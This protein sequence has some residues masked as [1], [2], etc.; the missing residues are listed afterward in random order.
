MKKQLLFLLVILVSFQINSQT[1]GVTK[2][3]ATTIYSQE[4]RKMVST[5]DGGYLAMSNSGLHGRICKMNSGYVPLWSF[6]IDS[7]PIFDAVETN[8]GN[9]VFTGI[10]YYSAYASGSVY[11]LKLNPTGTII[12]QKMYY[13]PSF[14][15]TLTTSGLG[16][17][18]G[19]D[20]G[21]V[22]FGGN[23]M[24]MHYMVKCDVNGV[25]QWENTYSGFGANGFF[26]SVITETNGY[27][28]D[29]STSINS[30]GAVYVLR[31]DANGVPS[32]AKVMQSANNLQFGFNSLAKLNNGDYFLWVQPGDINGA[33][34]Y[35]ISNSFSTITCNRISDNSGSTYF[36]GAIATGNANDDL[37]MTFVSYNTFYSGA[38]QVTPAGSI[39]WQ[40]YSSSSSNVFNAICA[41]PLHNG[42]NL[43]NGNIGNQKAAIAILDD[44]GNGF[45]STQNT[46]LTAT[47]NY[48]FTLTSPTI[49]PYPITIGVANVNFPVTNL[50]YTFQ[51]ICGNL[52]GVTENEI[53]IDAVNLF[54][55]PANNTLF[56]DAQNKKIVSISLFDM[57]G[58]KVLDMQNVNS[59]SSSIDLSNMSTG[60]Y[61]VTVTTSDGTFTGKIEHQ[62]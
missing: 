48:P 10:N 21:F 7:M 32:N 9:Y 13:D 29:G 4:F 31:I 50:T 39:V 52:T 51:N 30:L 18:V 56:V 43:I 33:Q 5:S 3:D 11:I 42:T 19:T 6:D 35:T 45:C 26:A 15:T 34:N 61:F 37:L 40:K 24:A 36:T 54:P 41:L 59:V 16:K 8:D 22:F 62:N 14:V 17:A 38:L 2:Y 57:E 58:K 55:N 12:F 20:Q 60:L 28:V 47:Q 53:N 1:T 27:V 49:T 25:I 46:S 44:N 23:C